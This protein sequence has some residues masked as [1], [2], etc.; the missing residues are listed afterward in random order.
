MIRV[1]EAVDIWAV[2]FASIAKVEAA[3]RET[4]T[5]DAS[6]SCYMSDIGSS[7]LGHDEQLMDWS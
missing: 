5:L 6:I 1:L 3:C 4:I 2:P 7:L